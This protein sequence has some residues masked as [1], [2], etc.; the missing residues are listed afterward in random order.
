MGFYESMADTAKQLLLQFGQNLTL[1]RVTSSSYNTTTGGV[2]TTTTTHTVRGAVFN[3]QNRQVDGTLIK[4]GDRQVYL[5]TQ[6]LSFI[7]D[8]TQDTLTISG[9]V[10]RILRCVPTIPAGIPVLYELQ[11][12]IGN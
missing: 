11:V 8:P 3:Y 12:R 9:T 2:T 5:S 6:N 7:P 10:Y 1:T 4:A